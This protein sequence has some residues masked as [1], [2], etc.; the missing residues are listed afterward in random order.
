MIINRAQL[1]KILPAAGMP[2][3]ADVFLDPLNAHMALGGI[4]TAARAAAFIAQIG[5]ESGQLYYT[6]ELWGPTAAQ[7]R[8]EGREDLGNTVKG[9]GKKF[10]GRGLIQITGRENYGAYSLHRYGDLRLLDTPSLL[11]DPDDAVGSAVWFWN[12]RG[13]SGLADVGNFKRI[14]KLINGGTNGAAEREE[15]YRRALAV[16]SPAQPHTPDGRKPNVS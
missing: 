9:D 12:T 10:M 3:R 16:L 11:E 13:L 2:G 7:A 6:R 5:H 15:F 8:Y 4:D 1:L 14:T